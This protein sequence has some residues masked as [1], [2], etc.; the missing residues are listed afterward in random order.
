MKNIINWTLGGFFRSFGRILCYLVIGG[1]IA[2]LIAVNSDKIDPKILG[3]KILG[4]E[5]VKAATIT[6]SYTRYMTLWC[7]DTSCPYT[8]GGSDFNSGWV[9]RNTAI[10]N[11]A[12]H[13]PGY[14]LTHVKF[15]TQVNSSNYLQVNQQYLIQIKVNFN[16]RYSD[17]DVWQV[18]DWYY[19][20]DLTYTDNTTSQQSIGAA[21]LKANND[22][23][24]INCS[25]TFQPTKQVKEFTFRILFPFNQVNLFQDLEGINYKS[26]QISGGTDATD[27]INNQ[28][29]VIENAINTT[30]E[31]IN[32]TNNLLNDDDVSDDTTD[33]ADFINDFELP[34]SSNFSDLVL[35]PITF[36][37]RILTEDS[38]ADLCTTWRNKHICLPNGKLIWS[39]SNATAFITFFNLFVG[40]LTCYGL[41]AMTIRMIDNI[42]N[43]A[44]ETGLELSSLTGYQP[45]HEG[46]MPKHANR[47]VKR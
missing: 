22:N 14:Y 40:G 6:P 38:T 42:L 5:Y 16:P 17:L 24:G 30:N 21:C 34:G 15:R 29:I 39:K 9:E 8:E 37:E 2:F 31:L 46:Y 25:F 23:Y 10:E 32:D 13:V 33:M 7:D 43:P 35:I 20:L 1:I 47:R 12:G 36:F 19:L 3:A 45:R 44:I 41:I 26:I 27:A 11:P 18:R 28:T 4:I